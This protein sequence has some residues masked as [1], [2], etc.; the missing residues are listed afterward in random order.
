MASQSACRGKTEIV[1][2]KKNQNLKKKKKKK[3]RPIKNEGFKKTTMKICSVADP[4]EKLLKKTELK[5]GERAVK[6]TLG[7][8]KFILC[9]Q[10]AFIIFQLF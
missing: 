9:S 8:P 1:I 4:L 5:V 6:K 3:K 10:E 7:N 2:G